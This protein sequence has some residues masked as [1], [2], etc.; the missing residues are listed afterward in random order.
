MKKDSQSHIWNE[1]HCNFEVVTCGFQK[2]GSR[3]EAFYEK[4]Y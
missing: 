3:K 2:Y 1:I 4:T